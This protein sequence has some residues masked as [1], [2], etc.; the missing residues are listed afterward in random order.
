M[1]R[2]QLLIEYCKT[3]ILRLFN[4]LTTLNTLRT[5]PSTWFEPFC[6][7]ITQ[8][9][10]R[11][12]EGFPPP[13]S[14]KSKNVS[15]VFVSLSKTPKIIEILWVVVEIFETLDFVFFVV[16]ICETKILMR[17]TEGIPPPKS[18][19]SKNV[20]GVFVPLSKTPK[21]IQIVWV[22]AEIFET[23]EKVFFR[24]KKTFL[25]RIARTPLTFYN[26]TCLSICD[27]LK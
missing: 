25:S 27:I 23:L 9:S 21:I 11:W 17:W 15:G 22:V 13:K 24:K 19:K 4:D 12:T 7:K 10:M 14:Y 26:S 20:S 3:I 8:T 6:I 18:Y 1:F 5:D 2:V 16:L